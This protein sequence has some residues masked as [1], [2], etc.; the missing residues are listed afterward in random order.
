MT[1]VIRHPPFE[2]WYNL[3]RRPSLGYLAALEFEWFMDRQ[4]PATTGCW[5]WTVASRGQ[6]LSAVKLDR[7]PFDSRG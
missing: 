1:D 5:G 2:T 3:R 4:P 6:P 7:Q